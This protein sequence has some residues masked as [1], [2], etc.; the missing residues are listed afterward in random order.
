MSIV[1]GKVP[2]TYLTIPTPRVTQL[3]GSARWPNTKVTINGDTVEFTIN[4]YKALV[5]FCDKHKVAYSV[6]VLQVEIFEIAESTL[7]ELYLTFD[8]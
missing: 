8:I 4:D 5:D 3:A 2:T 1:H 6:G 7:A